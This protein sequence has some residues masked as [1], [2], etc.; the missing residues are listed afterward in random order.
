M[1]SGKLRAFSTNAYVPKAKDIIRRRF[2]E[3][4]KFYVGGGPDY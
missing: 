2:E 4:Q 1:R 3:N